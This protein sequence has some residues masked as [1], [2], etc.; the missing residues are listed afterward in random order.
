MSQVR[1]ISDAEFESDVL[2]ATGTP[3]LAY[4]WASWCGPC[5]LM[6]PSIEWAAT[7]WG[8][9][10]KIVKLEID[11]NPTS[12]KHCHVEGVPALRLFK[13][14]QLIAESEGAL[15]KVKLADFLT[16]YLGAAASAV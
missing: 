1:V 12:V 14:G 5:R 8:E 9:Q 3:V 4:F 6:S 15:T 7:A 16:P 13:D 2:Q 10:L 11:P